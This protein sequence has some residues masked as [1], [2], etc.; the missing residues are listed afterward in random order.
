M[1]ITSEQ[2]Q[3]TGRRCCERYAKL[4]AISR[5]DLHTNSLDYELLEQPLTVY[6]DLD[7]PVAADSTSDSAMTPVALWQCAFGQPFH[8]QKLEPDKCRDLQ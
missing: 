6:V 3:G 7:L 8:L 1:C 4:E 5:Q 2:E